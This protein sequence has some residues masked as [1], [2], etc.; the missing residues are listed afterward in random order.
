[1]Y[2]LVC[3]AAN[4]PA[5]CHSNS[6][7][8]ILPFTLID[9]RAPGEHGEGKLCEPGCHTVLACDRLLPTIGMRAGVTDISYEATRSLSLLIFPLI[10][11][12][13]V[14]LNFACISSDNLQFTIY[15]FFLV[16]S[17]C[18]RS[19]FRHRVKGHGNGNEH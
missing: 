9:K 8:L 19:S 16:S 7:L 10:Y 11:N 3:L 18:V 17:V 12:S 5:C 13:L 1:M 14:I 6:H 2:W 15:V 4:P